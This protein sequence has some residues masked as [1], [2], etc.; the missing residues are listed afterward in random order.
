MI[1]VLTGD[2]ISAGDLIIVDRGIKLIKHFYPHEELLKLERWK[3][4]DD[5]LDSVN[6][7]RAI[8]L[9][10]GPA[11]TENLYPE[12]YPLTKDL[13]KITVPIIAMG[14]GSDLRPYNQWTIN[15]FKFSQSS[16]HLL[17]RLSK[18]FPWISVRDYI[19]QQ[20]LLKSG[21]HN[22]KVTGC[23]AWYNLESLGKPIACENI[24]TIAYAPGISHMYFKDSFLL[25]YN[26]IKRMSEMFPSAQKHCIY[27]DSLENDDQKPK[28]QVDIQRKFAQKAEKLGFETINC[29]NNLKK[30]AEA[31]QKTDL[32]VGAR[33]HSHIFMLSL[34]KPSFLIS[35][36]GRG[37]GANDFIG[38]KNFNIFLENY[39]S[40]D[41]V[42]GEDKRSKNISMKMPRH[43][44]KHSSKYLPIITS[45]LYK[46]EFNLL[47]VEEIEQFIKQELDNGFARYAGVHNVILH[48]FKHMENY[49]KNIP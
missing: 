35:E 3:P 25:Q 15:H 43:I 23:P 12:I 21:I 28:Y 40:T 9:L 18:D 4:I 32:L 2:I 45:R 5:K 36:D 38:L 30:L 47:L 14:L 29:T 17:D 33:V 13:S 1:T 6:K 42:T 41:W 7:S 44:K 26:I 48:N 24:D 16:Y 20:L 19:T 27:Q 22:A 31:Y 34:G 8:I 39:N 49:L 46:P 10:G 11:V 37:V